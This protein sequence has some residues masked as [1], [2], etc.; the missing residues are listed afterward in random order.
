MSTTPEEAEAAAAAAAA[1]ARSFNIELWTLYAVGICATGLRT[2]ARVRAVG[3]KSFQA[4][5]YL[6][7]VGAVR[8]S[9]LCRS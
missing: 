7:W 9:L 5:D 4:D 8:G 2:Y 1:A 6:V 3:I